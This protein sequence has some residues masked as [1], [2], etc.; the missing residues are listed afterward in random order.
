[1][2]IKLTINNELKYL[3]VEKDE[4]LLDTLRQN[5]YLSVRRGCDTTNCGVCTVLLDGKPVPSCSVL[6]V[7]ADGHVVTTVEGIPQ[8]AEKLGTYFGLEGAD[9]CGYCNPSVALT[10][11]AMKKE[12]K[13]P[14]DEDIKDY[15]VGNLCRCSG[16]VA[17]EK[18]VRKYLGDKS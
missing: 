6:S 1:M 11:Y 5:N 8:E 10:I 18:A 2:K 4:Y 16:Y 12:L 9:Q 14:T 7:V 3:H 13:N 17:Q 15:L